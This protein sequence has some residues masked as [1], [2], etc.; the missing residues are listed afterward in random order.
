MDLSTIFAI[1]KGLHSFVAVIGLAAAFL[2]EI[3]YLKNLKGLPMIYKILRWSMI[4]LIFTGFMFFVKWR[5]G[6][7]GAR[8]F[9]NGALWAKYTIV[10]ILLVNAVLMQAKKIPLKIGAPVSLVS[11]SAA[12]IFGKWH[13]QWLYFWSAM[14]GYIAVVIVVGF[15]LEAIKR[16]LNYSKDMRCP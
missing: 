9:F 12:F 2:A 15:I 3:F 7:G 4:I 8:L 16:K 13:P 6:L 5:L 14:A 11:W 10:A 1:N